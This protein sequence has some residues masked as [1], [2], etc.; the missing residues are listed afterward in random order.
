MY[1]VTFNGK[2]S[3]RDYGLYLST[4]PIIGNPE[5][6]LY[7]LEIPGRDGLLDLTKSVTGTVT[8]SN[9][10]LEFEFASMKT[11]AEQVAL[12]NALNND[13]HGK[14]VK[15]ILDEDSNYYYSGRASVEWYES[16]DWKTKCRVTVDAEPYKR[17]TTLTEVTVTFDANAPDQRLDSEFPL[18]PTSTES[19]QRISGM[20]F[21][22][23]AVP[24]LDATGFDYLKLYC[25]AASD[26]WS[27]IRSIY[28]YDGTGAV[29][30]APFPLGTTNPMI[31]V[32]DIANGGVDVSQIWKIF[33]YGHEGPFHG[34]AKC[35]GSSADASFNVPVPLTI[36]PTLRVVCTTPIRVYVGGQFHDYSASGEYELPEMRIDPA[37]AVIVLQSPDWA[38]A[39]ITLSFEEAF[40]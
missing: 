20:Y 17:K 34:G 5:P 16:A 10:T 36:S 18:N 9:R 19:T 40:I 24:T 39:E 27:G 29:Y 32:A 30:V 37:G 11:I 33:I 3:L 1:G 25:N 26:Q 14:E 8:Y 4:R 35:L 22:S 2:H 6:R 31:D 7:Q 38:D 23:K 12:R 21:G 28:F 15:V 13:L